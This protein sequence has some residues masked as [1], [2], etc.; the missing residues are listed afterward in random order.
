MIRVG[1]GLWPT[2][3]LPLDPRHIRTTLD[4]ARRRRTRGNKRPEIVES[5]L[6]GNSNAAKNNVSIEDLQKELLAILDEAFLPR[7]KKCLE[8]ELFLLKGDDSHLAAGSPGSAAT[9]SCQHDLP[10]LSK[11][12]LLAAFVCQ[13]NKPDKD[14]AL[15][16]IQK[17]GKKNNR[18]GHRVSNNDAEGLAFGSTTWEQQRLKMLRPRTFPL[19]RMLSVFVNIVGLIGGEEKLRLTTNST[20][21]PRELLSSIGSTCFF[22]NLARLR[23][24]G[25]L[26]EVLGPSTSGGEG[27]TSFD[28]INMMSTMYWCELNRE[29]AETLAA[30]VDF[31]LANFLL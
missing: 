12:I 22:E 30:S 16:T 11:C 15:F 5:V 7:M 9:S 27:F 17:N 1:R 6:L 28:G 3:I 31:P 10:Y 24:I 14:K 21:D 26:H 8:E 18:Q 23:E 4:A 19:E 20:A 13:S 25:L 2:Y 29:D